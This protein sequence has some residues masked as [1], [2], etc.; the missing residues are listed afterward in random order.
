MPRAWTLTT[1][2]IR[3]G[4][5]S[6]HSRRIHR[7]F[8]GYLQVH[9]RAAE[10]GRL[11]DVAPN[12]QEIGPWLQVDGGPPSKPFYR[13]MADTDVMAIS[14]WLNPNLAGS[15]APSSVRL[16]QPPG[17]VVEPGSGVFT[18]LSDHERLAREHLLHG[19]RLDVVALAAYYYRNHAFMSETEP[20]ISML[21]DAFRGDFHFQDDGAFNELFTTQ[22]PND[23]I[24]V[25]E[26]A[27]E[28]LPV[29]TA[30]RFTVRALDANDLGVGGHEATAAHRSNRADDLGTRSDDPRVLEITRLLDFYGGVLLSGPPGT[31]KTWYAAEVARLLSEGDDSRRDFVQFHQSYQ[32]ENFV[33]GFAP[34]ADGSGFE[35]QDGIFI[36]MCKAALDRPDET[37]ALVIDEFSRADVGRVF[38]EALTYMES[39]KRGIEFRLASGQLM[40]VPANLKIIATMNPLDRG[41][42]EVDAAFERRFGKVSMDPSREVL[43]GFLI[44]NGVEGAL[45]IEVL[46]FFSMLNR[47]AKVTPALAIG[48]AYF[49]DV[50]DIESL[51]R[52]W[53]YQLRHVVARAYTLDP[54]AAEEV[55][56]AWDR[57]MLLLG[58]DQ[59]SDEDDD[60]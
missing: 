24:H 33:Q 47:R 6:L 18:L 26:P 48:H 34:S 32:Y 9:K 40:S 25:F 1:P 49:L 19:E 43:E 30:P 7:F 23:P 17:R 29:T 54:R 53:D 38:G 44:S 52:V 56:D 3:W 5:E 46:N 12:V 2:F 51:R 50:V 4:I 21:V 8:P 20:D 16:T 58:A 59:G 15:F 14:Y 39:T 42:D 60:G 28:L 13:P 27:Q 55:H 36:R 57:M 11:T 31:S 10:E 22:G 37:F 35:M 41:V 45:W